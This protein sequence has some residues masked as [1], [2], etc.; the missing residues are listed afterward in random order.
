M[1]GA[2]ERLAERPTL[3]FD[4]GSDFVL[5]AGGLRR[6][7]GRGEAFAGYTAGELFWRDLLGLVHEEDLSGVESLLS[8]VVA[9]RGTC[10]ATTGAR[11]REASGG[12]MAAEIEI[13]KILEA[14]EDAGLVVADVRAAGAPRAGD[15]S[16][17]GRG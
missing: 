14:P 11:L 4:A 8:E 12:W 16:P 10:L 3:P 15:L 1:R 17:D 9:S 5:A 2:A 6:M 7:S 13:R